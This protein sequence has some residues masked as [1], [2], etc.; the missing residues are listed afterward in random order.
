MSNQKG[1]ARAIKSRFSASWQPFLAGALLCIFVSLIV[2]NLNKQEEENLRNEIRT[3][4]ENLAGHINADLRNRFSA[5]QRM[6]RKWD[7]QKRVSRQDF[8]DDAHA[9]L[10]YDPGF[11]ALEWADK[12]FIVRWVVPLRGNE[13]TQNL[14]LAFESE[15]RHALEKARDTRSPAGT[16]PV[17]LVQGGKGFLVFFP[18]YAHGR[19]EGV[20]LAAFRAEEWLNYVFSF[21]QYRK[22]DNFRA[23]VYLDGKLIFRQTGWND[24]RSAEYDTAA[25]AMVLDHRLTVHIRPAQ[26]FIDRSRTILPQLTAVF[27]FLVSILVTLILYL[28]GERKKAAEELNDTLSRLRLLLDS[29]AEA[30]YGIDL[31]GNCSFANN[32]VL[33]MLGYANID[34]LL[35]KNMH[36]L[37][38]HSYPDG[39]PMPVEEC[40]IY[41]AF[42]EGTGVHYDKEVFFRSDGT[43][44]PVEYWS[45]P[46]IA[47]GVVKGAVVTFNDI[48]ERREAEE[49]LRVSEERLRNITDSAK[50]AIIMMDSR[51]AISYWNPAAEHIFGYSAEEVMGKDLHEL[52]APKR[53][54]SAHRAALPEF[55]RTGRGDAVGTTRDLHARCKDGQ[56]IPVALSLSAVWQDGTWHAVGVIR[57]VTA[58]KQAEAAMQEAQKAAEAANQA[59]SDFL[60]TMS[61]EIRTPMNAITGMAELLGET[62]LTPEQER[63]VG[64][65]KNAGENLLMIIN[66]ILDLSKIEAGRI[67]IESIGFNL[68]EL[69]EKTCQVMAMRASQKGLEFISRIFPDVPVDV[70]GDPVRLRQIIVNLLSNAIKFTEHGEVVL[71]VTNE[72]PQTKDGRV[73]LTFSVR[74]SGI[75]ISPDKLDAIFDKFTQADSSTTRKYGGTGLGLPISRRL[76]QLMG[77]DLG[78]ES[79]PGKGTRFFF[80]IPLPVYTGQKNKKAADKKVEIQD[81]ETATPLNILLVDDSEDNRLLVRSFLKKYPYTIEAAENGLI[82]FELFRKGKYNLVLMD[83]QMPVMDG[84]TAMRQIRAWEKENGSE[85]TPI[86]ALTAYALEEEMR[87]SIEAGCDAHITKPIKKEVLLRTIHEYAKM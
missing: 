43:S 18:I 76:V 31:Q 14:N 36:N 82:A 86:V 85:R 22:S 47:G 5:L 83:M 54:L 60:A 81:S 16:G 37:I 69:I 25:E 62:T 40:L 27:G 56:E 24:S 63:Y 42:H 15:R 87:K 17:D 51:G 55:Q 29:T 68:A 6:A 66:D 32:S 33:R 20:V 78:V 1:H 2:G 72:I 46:Q 23:S 26:G 52:L 30:I 50:D 19:F 59:K 84:Y 45:Y 80:T 61:H 48:T 8:V 11:Q 3:E 35:G 70:V 39:R 44:F 77:G 28:L 65:F 4:A 57:D 12:N 10:S 67:D 7:V 9:Y 21:K 74:D 13:Q 41:R 79:E 34:D 38:H 71:E 75:G 49:K 64:I 58:Q 53:Y 73:Y